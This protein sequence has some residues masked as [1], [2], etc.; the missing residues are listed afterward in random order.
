MIIVPFRPK[1]CSYCLWKKPCIS[2]KIVSVKFKV[3]TKVK[4]VEFKKTRAIHE[5]IDGAPRIRLKVEYKPS[6]Y[7]GFPLEVVLNKK[8]YDSNIH[9]LEEYVFDKA[10]SQIGYQKLLEECLEK[11]YRLDYCDYD[12]E[13][14]IGDVDFEFSKD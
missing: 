12:V 3:I 5:I 9:N 11:G 8:E 1:P 4:F 6:I 14:G 10:T 13:M 2:S 7:F